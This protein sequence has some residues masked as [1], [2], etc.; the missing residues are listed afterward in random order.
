MERECAR[1]KAELVSVQSELDKCRTSTLDRWDRLDDELQ[2]Q[3]R[4]QATAEQQGQLEV[5]QRM[6]VEEQEHGRELQKSKE[7]TER[8]LSRV[9]KEWGDAQR[10][11]KG[12][13]VEALQQCRGELAA[14]LDELTQVQREREDAVERARVG[15]EELA[16]SKLQVAQDRREMDEKEAE[17]VSGLRSEITAR[18][19]AYQL[20]VAQHEAALQEKGSELNEQSSLVEFANAARDEALKEAVEAKGEAERL[21]GAMEHD[22]VRKDE[23]EA[24]AADVEQGLRL[25]LQVATDELQNSALKLQKSLALEEEH[26]AAVAIMQSDAAQ[27]KVELAQSH[28]ANERAG[29]EWKLE[30]EEL[31]VENRKA[32]A[33][34]DTFKLRCSMLARELQDIKRKLASTEL[35]R[36]LGEEYLSLDRPA[37][38]G[39]ADFSCGVTIR[40]VLPV[41]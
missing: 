14:V 24:A 2:R 21:R 26:R 41:A 10:L 27:L 38:R 34:R 6:L 4:D 32:A 13:E 31:C 8:E 39:T 35:G 18:D 12:R 30:K 3:Q 15:A 1:L 37:T 22:S 33:A 17:V 19:A 5:L 40:S 29:T 28:E 25:Q 23:A 16:R 11:A 9:S 20:L 7:A 36:S